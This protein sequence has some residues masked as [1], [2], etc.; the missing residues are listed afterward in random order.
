[1]HTQGQPENSRGPPSPCGG[2]RE[3]KPEY[4]NGQALKGDLLLP[5][6][7]TNESGR[8]QGIRDRAKGEVNGDGEAVVLADHST[9]GR[10]SWKAGIVEN[11]DP[12][13]PLKGR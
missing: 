11:R 1:M 12:R 7:N 3:G 2:Y 13:D 5:E 10:S 8:A 6:S 9:D 4:K